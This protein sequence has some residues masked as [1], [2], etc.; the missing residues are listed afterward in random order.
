MEFQRRAEQVPV[1]GNAVRS[2]KQGTWSWRLDGWL[3]DHFSFSC[4]EKSAFKTRFLAFSL[5][6]N[7]GVTRGQL[8]PVTCREVSSQP[9]NKSF[10]CHQRIH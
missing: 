9:T 2:C 4:L 7:A 6:R 5:T 10:P 3:G 1:L 8:S